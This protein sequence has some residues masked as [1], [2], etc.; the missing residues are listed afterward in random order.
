M[1]KEHRHEWNLGDDGC[2]HCG[3][4]LEWEVDNGTITR[5]WVNNKSTIEE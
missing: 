2:F 4:R 3:A 5:Y 1:K